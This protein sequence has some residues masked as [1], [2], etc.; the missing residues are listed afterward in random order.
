MSK[1]A[2]ALKASFLNNLLAYVVGVAI[3]ILSI[4]SDR[5][6]ENIKDAINIS[7][8]RVTIYESLAK[9]IG[10]YLFYVDVLQDG[11]EDRWIR[12]SGLNSLIPKYNNSISQLRGNELLYISRVKRFWGNEESEKLEKLFVE[13]GSLDDRVHDLNEQIGDV[14]SDFKDNIDFTKTDD[15]AAAMGIEIN[16]FRSNALSFL[17]SLEN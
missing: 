5:I 8:S 17:N 9:D 14:T 11:F 12:K 6:T 7:D 4:F 15:I 3:A 16:E 1:F 13:L 2:T 10:Y